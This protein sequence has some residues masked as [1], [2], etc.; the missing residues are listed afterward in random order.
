LCNIGQSGKIFHIVTFCHKRIRLRVMVFNA[1]LN[2][3]SVIL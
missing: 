2:S 1:T 3:I